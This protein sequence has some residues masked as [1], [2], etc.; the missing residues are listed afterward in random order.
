MVSDDSTSKVIVL[1]VRVLTKICIPPLSLNTKCKVDSFWMFDGLTGQGLHKDL[2]TTSQS[3]HQVESRLLLDVVIGKGSAVF[4]LLTGENQS[5]LVWW[6]ALLVL[7][8]ALD[9][10]NRVRR[11]NLKSNGLSGQS[12]DK[13]LHTSSQSQHQVE[14]RLLLNVVVRQRSAIL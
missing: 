3:K 10:V 4:Q 12:L 7:D 9:V 14:S 1:P 2:H 8:L 5:L 13:D 11:L 6:N